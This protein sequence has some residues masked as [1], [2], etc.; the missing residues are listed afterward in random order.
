MHIHRDIDQV[1]RELRRHY[2]AIAVEQLHVTHPADDDG[3][4]FFT[5]PAGRGEVQV[6]STTGSAPFI[7][8]GDDDPR[9]DTNCSIA[10]TVALVA[11][12]LGLPASASPN[13]R[14]S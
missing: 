9:A 10:E 6:E 11:S 3:I 5:H 4:W 12:R 2:P 14:C 7:V 8:E 13:V 1:I